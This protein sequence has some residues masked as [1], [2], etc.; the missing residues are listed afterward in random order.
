MSGINGERG[1]FFEALQRP[2]G[3]AVNVMTARPVVFIGSSKEGFPVAAA[4]Q[5][6]LNC[7]EVEAVLWTTLFEPGDL[8]IEA[9]DQKSFD[10]DFAVFVFSSDA[11]VESRGLKTL[12]P[13]D[14]LLLEFGLFVGRM[15]RDRVFYAFRSSDRLKLP[16]DLAGTTGVEY[17]ES[18]VFGI[19]PA[20][21]KLSQQLKRRILEFGPRLRLPQLPAIRLDFSYLPEVPPTERGWEAG[22]NRPG[23]P[24][25]TINVVNDHRFGR[26]LSMDAPDGAYM[27]CDLPFPV[28]GQEVQ[29]VC[30]GDQWT[31]YPVIHI[32][33]PG[34]D[35]PERAYLRIAGYDNRFCKFNNT[36]WFVRYRSHQIESGWRSIEMSIPTLVKATFET[37][38]W[39]YVDFFRIRLRGHVTLASV[40]IFA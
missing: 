27:D 19:E 8:T 29:F 30:R 10:F 35:K 3:L 6:T 18:G 24:L 40:A 36:E 5:A 14:N 15:G 13:R 2:A 26:C 22:H 25:P 23:G 28:R 37:E 34:Q 21:G 1:I 38:G 16:S 32:I 7:A 9:L 31:F 17:A 11:V 12:A 4:I 33:K 39:Q 20:I